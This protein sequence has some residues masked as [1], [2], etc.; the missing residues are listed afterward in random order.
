MY[1]KRYIK[2]DAI[3]MSLA[4]CHVE[5]VAEIYPSGSENVKGRK[6]WESK[7]LGEIPLRRASCLT[8][9]EFESTTF[10]FMKSGRTI[11]P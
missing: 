9:R 3:N 7:Q 6:C 5:I 8:N 10:N 2:V 11:S 4:S 1:V